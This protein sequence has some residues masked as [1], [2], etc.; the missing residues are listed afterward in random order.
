MNIHNLVLDD[1][2]MTIDRAAHLEL[3]VLVLAGIVFGQAAHAQQPVERGAGTISQTLQA[4]GQRQDARRIALVIGN[5]GY[6][7][8]SRLVN[9]SNDARLIAGTLQKAGFSLVGGGPQIDL[10]KVRFDRLV[11]EFGKQ[12]VGAEVAL[13]Y[14]SGHGMQVQGE[15]W[16]VPVDANPSSAKDLDF[17]MVDASL[18]LRQME[19]SGT[20]L[21]MLILDACRNNPFPIRGIR[22]AS[23]GLGEMAAPEGTLISYATQPGNVALD[24]DSGDSPYTTALANA[25]QRPGSDVFH[26]FNEVGLLVKQSTGG[27]QQ[28]WLATSP[29]AGNFF[30][31]N[32]PAAIEQRSTTA[33]VTPLASA[34]VH[35]AVTAF[36]GVWN[37]D[38]VCPT[39]GVAGGYS[40]HFAAQVSGGAL[41]GQ[42]GALGEPGS[43]TI[44]GLINAEGVGVITASGRTGRKEHNVQS[45]KSAAPGTPYTYSIEAHFSAAQGT[46]SRLDG[47]RT[48]TYTFNPLSQGHNP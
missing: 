41:H 11:Q 46:G 21:N 3:A 42:Y 13:F 22:A 25:I 32:G 20:K 39:E 45:A 16:L 33:D 24:G 15:N 43:L 37:V 34:P 47:L 12:L 18:V 48:C 9:P 26:V 17:E 2:R 27:A 5:G 30:F 10:D 19:N 6:R 29:I 7:N 44:D 23:G 40:F 31:F 28:P 8:V 1:A 35:S 14:Y 38:L 4:P 36:D